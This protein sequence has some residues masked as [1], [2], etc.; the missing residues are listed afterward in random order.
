MA[1]LF[2]KEWMEHVRLMPTKTAV[3]D[4]NGNRS[5]T[6]E[7]MNQVADQFA[8]YYQEQGIGKG[9]T[10]M[11]AASRRME[12]VAAEIGAW[13]IGCAAV[14][15][16]DTYPPE[17][18]LTMQKDCGC[19]II[20]TDELIERIID[21]VGQQKVVE[22][23]EFAEH[24]TALI[25]YTSGSTGKPKG[26]SLNYGVV[27][28]KITVYDEI[29]TVEEQ[30]IY[31]SISPLNFISSLMDIFY[32]LWKG[33]TVHILSQEVRQDIRKVEDYI[34]KY[35]ISHIFIS[36][37]MLKNFRNKSDNLKVVFTGSEKVTGFEHGNYTVVNLY[38]M[39]EAALVVLF[40]KT[41]QGFS[42]PFPLGKPIKEYEVYLLNEDGSLV[43]DGNEGEICISGPLADG[44]LNLPEQTK[45]V[46][47]DNPFTQ[48]DKHSRLYH[49]GDFGK[50]LADGNILY[51]NRRDWMVKVNGQRV[52]IGEIETVISDMEQIQTAIVKGFT[53]RNGQ[54]YLCAYY[55]ADRAVTK[56]E[57]QDRLSEAFPSYMIPSFY[58]ELDELPKNTNGKLDRNALIEPDASMFRTSYCSP[59]TEQE[60]ILCDGFETVLGCGKVGRND[61]FFALGGNSIN[62]LSLIE[63]CN[64]TGLNPLL[65]FQGKTPGGI[66]ELLAS[67][68]Q[69]VIYK[70]CEAM[71]EHYPLTDSQ[72]GVY[73]ECIEHPESTMYNIPF[74]LRAGAGQKPD[75]ER[76]KNAICTAIRN[77]P[78]LQVCIGY[79]G[80]TPVMLLTER[81]CEVKVSHMSQEEWKEYRNGFVR[82][83]SIEKEPLYRFEIVEA[84]NGCYLLGDVHHLVFDGTSMQVLF[85]DIRRAYENQPL[86]E[87]KLTLF[88]MAVSE[89]TIEEAATYKEG[90]AFFEKRLSGVEIDSTLLPDLPA[91]G[92]QAK[93]QNQSITRELLGEISDEKLGAFLREH[94][95]TVS[96]LFM[97]AFAYTL[98]VMNASDE[99]LFCTA[100]NGRHDMRLKDSVGMF[101]RTMPV[102]VKVNKAEAPSDFVRQLQNEFME[103]M[104]HDICRFRELAN[105]FGIMSNIMFVYQDEM[106]NG[107]QLSDTNFEMTTLET[108]P[109]ADLALMI[110]K[111]NGY[112]EMTI[113]YRNGLYSEEFM[114]GFAEIL[115]TV[116]VEM[117]SAKRL[118]AINPIP[119]SQKKKMNQFNRTEV[120]Y[121]A[122]KSVVDL[123]CEQA[124]RDPKHL[125]VVYKDTKLTYQQLN[126]ITDQIG[127]YIHTQGIGREN[128]V[129]ILVRRSEYMPICALGVLKSGAAYQPLDPTYPLDRLQF[130]MK[131]AEVKLLIADEELVHLVPDFEG[132]ILLTKEICNLPRNEQPL[133]YPKPKD[134][135]VLL[136]TSGSTGVPKGCMLE[137]RNVVA[138]CNW[139]RSYYQINAESAIAAYA[140]FGFDAAVM[141][142]F[143]A[144]TSGVC[145]Y[146]IPE[147][148]RLELEELNR[149]FEQHH[150]TNAFM[151]TQVGRQ[152][153]VEFPNSSLRHL[154][155]GGE[156]LVPL[157]IEGSLQLSNGYGPSE[158]TICSSI[159]KVEDYR[160]NVPIGKPLDNLKL[161]V[162]DQQ[163]TRLPIGATGELCVSGH[164]VSR[165]YLN[166]PE[167]TQTAFVSNPFDREAGYERMY[168]TG[169]IVRLLYDGN[170]QFVGRKDSQVK[171]RGFRIELTEVEEVIRRYSAVKDATVV[172]YDETGGGK[173]LAAY[174]V[175]DEKVEIE[176]LNA[177]ILETK[178][179]YMVP[180]VTMQIDKI[181]LNQN[182][183]VN[184]RALPVPQK[185]FEDVTPPEN[186]LQ[187]QL[188]DIISDVIKTTDFG[189]DTDI[190]YAG[191][192]SIG[193]VN[194]NVKLSKAF[195]ITVRTKDLKEHNTVRKL[196]Q[197]VQKEMDNGIDDGVYEMQSDY[198]L[199]QTQEGIFVECMAHPDS[200]IYNIP[201]LLKLGRKVNV[202][203]LT[204]A[205]QQTVEAHPYVKLR[206]IMDE[207]GDIRQ[208]RMD[209]DE[210]FQVQIVDYEDIETEKKEMVKPFRFLGGALIRVRI[211]RGIDYYLFI[212]M[213]HIIC[214]GT[215][216][217]IFLQDITTAYDG[218]APQ[219]ETFSGFEQS[220][221][222]E[223]ERQGEGYEK[224]KNYYHA[225]L[226]GCDT[227][228]LPIK[229]VKPAKT[230]AGQTS[231]KM[232][233]YGRQVTTEDV[234]HFCRQNS[235]SQNAFFSAAF[236]MLVSKFCGKEQALFTTI[237]HGRNDSRLEHTISMLVKTYPVL[238]DVK[239][240]EKTILNLL[241]E[242]QGQLIESTAN[243][244]YSFAEICHEFGINADIMFAY[245]GEDFNFDSICGE[246]CELISLDLDETKA[247]VNVNVF[248]V[249]NKIKYF[250]EY[251]SD[252]FERS[253]MESLLDAYEQVIAEFLQKRTIREV[254]VLS[255]KAKEEINLFNDNDAELPDMLPSRLFEEQVEH[256]PQKAAVIAGGK[257]LTYQ[258]LNE[259]ANRV[260][261]SLIDAK[262]K[263]E[264]IVALMLHRT[265]DVYAVREGILKSGG[266]FLSMEPDY[267]D[268]R[269]RYIME[270]S[271]AGFLITTNA[272]YQERKELLDSLVGQVLFLEDL[273]QNNKTENPAMIV[274]AENLAYCIY[275]SG[276]TGKPKGV[277]IE[278]GNL[279]NMLNDC[280][281]NILAR[282]YVDNTTVFLGLAALTFDVSVIEEMMPLYH[283]QTVALAT[284]DEIHNPMLLAEM[285][286]ENGVDMM[287]CTPSYMLTIMEFPKVQE[288]LRKLRAII[289]GAEAFPDTLYQ[290]MRDIGMT[291]R[292]FNSYGPTETTVTV[293]IDEL[294]GERVT[295]GKPANNVTIVM[296]DLYGHTL[297]KY[298]PGEL[299]IVGK[300]VGRGYIGLEKMTRDKFFDF[301]GRRAYRSGDIAYWNKDGKIEF[302]GRGDNQVKLRGLRV[303]LDE[304]EHVICTYPSVK[305]SVVL[306][307]ENETGQYLCGYFMAEQS[308][309]L[310]QLTA[311]LQ[312]YLTN[313]MIPGMFM[314]LESFPLNQNGKID[315]KALPEPDA[316]QKRVSVVKKPE[317]ELQRQLCDIFKAAIGIE[318]ISI[319]DDFFEMGGTSLSASKVVMKC[320]VEKLPVV[321]ANIFD[322][323]TVEKLERFILSQQPGKNVEIEEPH[324]EEIPE[325]TELDQVLRFNTT[326]YVDEI[327]SEDIGTVLLSGATGFLGVHVLKQL[328]DRGKRVYCLV[329]PSKHMSAENR[330]KMMLVYYF[331]ESYDE[332]F[333][334]QILV[335]QGDITDQ[336]LSDI[337][338]DY[339]F[340]T[341]INCAACVKHFVQDDLL[342]RINVQG[343]K[344]LISICKGRGKKLIQI[345]TVSVAG[346]SVAGSVP[347]DH[348]IHE[349]ELYFG[350]NLDNKYAETKFRAE[351]AMLEA[352]A[353]GLRG[354][355]IRVGNLMSRYEDGEFQLNYTTNGFMKRLQAYAA[356]GEFPMEDLDQRAE[357]SPIDVTARAIVLLAGTNDQFTVFHAYNCHTVHMANV[358]SVM[359]ENGL[360]VDVVKREE[361]QKKFD[362]LLSDETM[363]MKISSLISYKSNEERH[364][365]GSENE[366]TVKALYRLG[367]A[368]P[369]ADYTYLKK[370][371]EALKT[372]GFFD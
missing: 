105:R 108:E 344:N 186:E 60:K 70:K 333:G 234:Q 285:M 365:I 272:L 35:Q 129:A 100:N 243:D 155:V 63:K 371:F 10:I 184:K 259:K 341:V 121:D 151:T 268:E 298:A 68:E 167:Q 41:N 181:P 346:E 69:E 175:S 308:I 124:D 21:S 17:R 164:Q 33:I 364:F 342:D 20:I 106:L 241:S 64:L 233:F 223:R 160:E 195:Q 27:S 360:K 230:A 193:A 5:T 210:S 23:C 148:I 258:E 131:D 370:L 358:I 168:H 61:N 76:F 176:K 59:N 266:A 48:D 14:P 257:K 321:Y 326:Q 340:D 278:Q 122:E 110:F 289:I 261:N 170:I 58:I 86:Q 252:L 12:Y 144:L 208:R 98:S 264:T 226:N 37:Q 4:E 172:A 3:I 159:Y 39:S 367:F 85:E 171:I 101:V 343:V 204:T 215:S 84:E 271:K 189:V 107:F 293:T 143:S 212:E 238:C 57:I 154:L 113:E 8:G 221:N 345:S 96:S 232:E 351:E 273:Y 254:S 118:D 231:A 11:V 28:E 29:C 126:E 119:D 327:A 40:Y 317:T 135:F 216:L 72:M 54:T 331:S 199:T 46:F 329:R 180:A 188:F 236:G 42:E 323:T 25:V 218:N 312:K 294:D 115:N 354:K 284:E 369:L 307:K 49:T 97:G 281:Q 62:V 120:F 158:C 165:G 152:F 352:I 125:A 32:P 274:K 363:S 177:F 315:K 52:E 43:E 130:M 50:R 288:A 328:I 245:Q 356:I 337:V 187:Q 217:Q 297:P 239:D 213:H 169:D 182:Q 136:Y 31:A 190:Y 34:Q 194:L 310:S 353:S 265:V 138:F 262:V 372:L 111:R 361:F 263:P 123:F 316:I 287:K 237:Y 280:D 348:R 335:V 201:I 240:G 322:Y 220:L 132:V 191:L 109:Q 267:P 95:I 305:R 66:A 253:Q 173:Y 13:K 140:S 235:I 200:T 248:L 117:I 304:I 198:P 94:A 302:C 44:Y 330:L 166:R 250:C 269:I 146:I 92:E 153:A 227:E 179:P 26:I 291:A 296:R 80:E 279:V 30:D 196:E 78:V 141:E 292:I 251:R 246:R 209:Y 16:A 56:D 203:R 83:F 53:N 359:N 149:Y 55:V 256:N 247:P 339:D 77:H 197:Y 150:I 91:M 286:I 133:E 319:D 295:I 222:E 299:T 15:A 156:A 368:W 87:E 128:A 314:Q 104:S 51:V 9:D 93:H 202:E 290:K 192:T 178:P 112:Y 73:L 338:R 229:T 270:D 350:Q 65:V 325:M 89:E 36:S 7:K 275:T 228:C 206:M 1:A 81:D 2:L 334:N 211:Y 244:S 309:D 366:F 355:I 225:L 260:A 137:H 90:L 18:I 313:Y 219:K 276:S 300:S 207:N 82:P 102:Y 139:Y 303:E 47:T 320:M 306:V 255:A 145:V 301:H 347:L 183:K 24:D 127:H 282:D 79:A 147:E 74:L 205:I 142:L 71:Q 163:G 318:E 336:S 224:A 22:A 6:Y 311:H 161:Y 162:V 332:M 174:I 134:L 249:G 324:A 362:E 357:F 349:N 242:M 67:S 157:H 38:G 103:I 19:Q 75:I 114:D 277:M 88:D 45:Q 116:L 99:V 214:D 185:I 283:G